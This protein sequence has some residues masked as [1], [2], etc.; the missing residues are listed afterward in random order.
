MAKLTTTQKSISSKPLS[1]RFFHYNFL[2]KATVFKAILFSLVVMGLLFPI[3]SS[4][5]KSLEFSPYPGAVAITGT[6]V[7]V[8]ENLSDYPKFK[9]HN[10]YED[11]THVVPKL[12]YSYGENSYLLN[13]D[14][15][16][17]AEFVTPAKNT[18]G[19]YQEKPVKLLVDSEDPS[20]AI[21]N[22]YK[23]K[24][25]VLFLT[26]LSSLTLLAST[27]AFRMWNGVVKARNKRK[28][29]IAKS[30]KKTA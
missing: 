8:S 11:Y 10:G 14:E 18:D 30:S 15:P 9:A 29:Q 4:I 21:V 16:A 27:V 2:K 13:A 5:Q 20:I 17:P 22:E 1:H 28:S 25:D 24:F 3:A 19:T 26:I 6:I 12:K 7:D 23:P